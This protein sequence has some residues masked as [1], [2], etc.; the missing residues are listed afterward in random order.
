MAHNIV[1]PP[2]P[3]CLQ[4]LA[5]WSWWGHDV[6]KQHLGTGSSHLY[7]GL[8]T[9]GVEADSVGTRSSAHGMDR[10][11]RARASQMGRKQAQRKTDPP[12]HRRVC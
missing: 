5:F 8:K 7:P 10:T 1:A 12:L 2:R 4:R 3:E 11:Q 9:A 6:I